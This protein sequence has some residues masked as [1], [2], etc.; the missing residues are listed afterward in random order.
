MNLLQ[1]SSLLAFL[2]IAD[3][4]SLIFFGLDKLRSMKNEWR[5]PE[6]G[7]LLVAFFGPFGARAHK[8]LE[9]SSSSKTLHIMKS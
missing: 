4:I 6:T 8:P 3:V 9:D 2:V 1:A 5:I 7:L